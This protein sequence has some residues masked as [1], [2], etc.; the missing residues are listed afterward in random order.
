M[1]AA[2]CSLAVVDA[3]REDLV[4]P[5]I[6]CVNCAPS[7]TPDLCALQGTAGATLSGT[8]VPAPLLSVEASSTQATPAAAAVREA[9][10]AVPVR[11][12]TRAGARGRGAAAP[13]ADMASAAVA[14]Q[15]K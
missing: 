8:A 1:A 7:M 15:R 14:T 9:Q 12:P 11:V 5:P 4:C 3:D 6:T 13:T 2:A 10:V